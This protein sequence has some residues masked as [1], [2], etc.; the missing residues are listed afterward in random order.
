MKAAPTA[1]KYKNFGIIAR[2][3]GSFSKNTF[4]TGYIPKTRKYA[5]PIVFDG[6]K[7]IDIVDVTSHT[8]YGYAPFTY[9]ST[10][11]TSID[12]IAPTV[13]SIISKN[14]DSINMTAERAADIELSVSFFVAL[15]CNG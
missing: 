6:N 11:T 14:D 1:V 4:S 15:I 12:A 8:R 10:N 9:T 13:S 2:P 5:T 3:R 7:S